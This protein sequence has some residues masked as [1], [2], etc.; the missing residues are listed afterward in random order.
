LPC[1]NSTN[2]YL[3]YDS[4][5]AVFAK[6]GQNKS[7]L[8]DARAT[9]RVAPERWQGYARAARLFLKCNKIDASI[10]MV[11]MALDRLSEGNTERRESL[12]SLQAD[13]IN[14]QKQTVSRRSDQFRKLPVEIF[15]EIAAI[16]VRQDSTLLL[17]LSHVSKQWRYVVRNH[18]ALW[19]V[20]VLSRRRP[21]EKAILWVE[22]SKGIIKELSVQQ[23]ALDT[24]GWSGDGLQRLKWENL[25]ICKIQKWDIMAYLRSISKPKALANLEQLEIDDIE[26]KH[27][28]IRDPMFNQDLKLQHLSMSYTIVNLDKLTKYVTNL[29]RLT[30]RYTSSIGELIGF[31]AVNALLES[32][33][34]HYVGEDTAT[35]IEHFTMPRL[36]NL[37]IRGIA[38]RPIFDCYMPALRVLRLDSLALPLD[39]V[40]NKMVD[41]SDIHLEELLLRSCR[42]VDS[43]S[44]ILLL[45]NSPDLRF[46]EV[47]NIAYQATSIIEALAASFPTTDPSPITRSSTDPSVGTPVLCPYL[48][49]VDFSRCPDI[50]TGSLVR[51]V[52]SRLPLDE[53]PSSYYQES[54]RQPHDVKR[55]VSLAMDCCPLVDADFLSWFRQ[56]VA[57]V[58]CVYVKKRQ[59]TSK[60]WTGE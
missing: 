46:L 34:L 4:R 50:R 37:E 30:L 39:R 21:K 11:T 14:A 13:I 7:A 48:T 20:L 31:L 28:L 33:V 60:G 10:A 9:I 29:T 22:R 2:A 32:L 26:L 35:T 16:V 25:R 8:E 52:K 6:L 5:A 12:L 47:S 53:L 1:S 43:Q 45:Q 15:G 49:N 36:F 18:N 44:V 41:E 55:I 23:G 57:N 54:A 38:P 58:N 27:C 17:P 40:L 51:L 59:S 3:V 24:R 42:F 19:S 56:K